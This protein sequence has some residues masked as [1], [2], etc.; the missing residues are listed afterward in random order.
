[1]AFTNKVANLIKQNVSSNLVSGFTNAMSGSLGQPKKIAAVLANK[2][3]LD[4]TQSPVA[5]MQAVNNPFQFGTVHYPEETSNLGSGHYIIFDII[6][7]NITGFG[8]TASSPNQKI[9]S[10]PKTLGQVGEGKF[11]QD[12]RL[13]KLKSQGFM[14]SNSTSIIR[15]QNTGMATSFE[16]HSRIASSIVLYSPPTNKF[17]YKVGYDGVDT[18]LA[19]L[20]ASLFDG[21]NMIAKL[22]DAGIGFLETI[23]KAAI[24][25]ALP[26]YGGV[27]DKKY[28]RVQNPKT[29]LIFKGVPF[30]NFNFPFE[31]SPKNEKEKD[32]MYKIINQFKFFMMP[33]IKS[34]GYLSA[35]SEF[36]ITYM[37]RDGANMYIPKIT[38]CVLTDMTLDFAPEGVFTT[39]KADDQGA[40]PVLTKMDLSF[41]ELE[42]MTKETIAAGH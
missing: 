30:R 34:E 33:E 7:N 8:G 4:L 5:H 36:Q 28:G 2:S 19:G 13:S 40:P 20:L 21:K 1:M 26:G 22:K 17:E 42:I 35:P 12:R 31:F 24:E 6:E 3:P 10:Y 23:S 39:F 29:E 16:T 25:I 15:K 14:D 38:R 18:A 11:N 9:K 41:T 37:Y 27:I 32:A